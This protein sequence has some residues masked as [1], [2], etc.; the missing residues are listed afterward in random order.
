MA[1]AYLYTL[2][3]CG[4][5]SEGQRLALEQGLEVRE[6]PVDNPLVEL[7]VRKLFR[8]EELKVPVLV[9]EERGIY[10]LSDS[11][12]IQWL[13]IMSLELAGVKV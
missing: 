12:P 8:H 10:V 13:R 11:E 4:A 2:P 6:I 7:G 1:R 3:N 5:C 9:I